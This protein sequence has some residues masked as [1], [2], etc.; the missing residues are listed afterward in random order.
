[1]RKPWARVGGGGLLLHPKN[2]LDTSTKLDEVFKWEILRI[3]VQEQ[4]K[5]VFAL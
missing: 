1:M 4:G 3:M 5:I 2:Y